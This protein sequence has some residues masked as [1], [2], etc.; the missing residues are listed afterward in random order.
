MSLIL[1]RGVD[2][3]FPSSRRSRGRR[4]LWSE[5]PG[6]PAASAYMKLPAIR[7]NACSDALAEKLPGGP[8]RSRRR[9]LRFP[10]PVPPRKIL[11]VFHAKPGRSVTF[12]KLFAV[13]TAGNM[14]RVPQSRQHERLCASNLRRANLS[15]DERRAGLY[16]RLGCRFLCA[17][18]ATATPNSRQSPLQPPP[19]LVGSRPSG[20]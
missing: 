20:L 19:F 17:V 7:R 10:I 16:L 8:C 2:L 15:T 9:E 13:P 14:Q 6:M 1:G 11:G 5:S 18:S 12:T 3:G 4:F